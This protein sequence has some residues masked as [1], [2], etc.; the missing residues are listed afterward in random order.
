MISAELTNTDQGAE[1]EAFVY[2]IL[3][4]RFDVPVEDLSPTTDLLELGIDSLGGVEVGLELM[5]EYGV[6]F[7][8]GDLAVQCTVADIIDIARLKLAELHAGKS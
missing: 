4:N 7:A 6:T 5:R 2:E 8:A 1:I 3:A